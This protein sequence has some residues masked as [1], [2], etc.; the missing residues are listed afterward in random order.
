MRF[1]LQKYKRHI[2]SIMENM[3]YTKLRMTHL[4][5]NSKGFFSAGIDKCFDYAADIGFIMDSSRSVNKE[6]FE[7]Q[8]EFIIS[9]IRNFQISVN[10]VCNFTIVDHFT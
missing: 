6:D 10:E 1:F 5:N 4:L 9:V 7:R 3:L 8:K 2:I